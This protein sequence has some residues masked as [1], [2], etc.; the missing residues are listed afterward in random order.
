MAALIRFHMNGSLSIERTT[1]QNPIKK[2]ITEK[3]FESI[4]QTRTKTAAGVSVSVSSR[5]DG[6]GGR[7]YDR[8]IA[9]YLCINFIKK[10]GGS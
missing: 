9:C 4:Y 3:S 8:I 6:R 2:C 10:T 5:S 7:L 1:E